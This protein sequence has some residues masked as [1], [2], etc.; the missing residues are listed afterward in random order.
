M[1][2]V[3]FLQQ[4]FNALKGDN[5]VE[6]LFKDQTIP[7]DFYY[8]KDEISKY[9]A[10][11]RPQIHL[12]RPHQ[13]CQARNMPPPKFIVGTISP[14]D[15]NQGML[16][17]CWMLSSLSSLSDVPEYVRRVV[18]FD[19]TFDR[20]YCGMFHFRFW[21]LGT[22][23]DVVIDDLLRIDPKSYELLCATGRNHNKNEFWVPLLEK[24]FAKFKG[25][26][27]NIEGGFPNNAL[28]N[29]TGGMSERIQTKVY[30]DQGYLC[31]NDQLW[32]KLFESFNSG[33]ILNSIIVKERDD[34]NSREVQLPN[35]LYKGHA[36][37][38]IGVYDF[39]EEGN[40][41]YETLRYPNDPIDPNQKR[42][43]IVQ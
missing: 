38:I 37:S 13:I 26:Y 15:I 21:K 32:D 30:N 39:F 22:W 4:D 14:D 11:N 24:A 31:F 19:Q 40:G 10:H 17:D 36:Y 18:P 20:E 29:F 25:S 5:R 34:T 9:P 7:G 43:Q 33:A 12:C 3:P 42:I 16:G 27:S 35:G 8:S 1:I 28:I 2:C 23:F 6:K 41:I